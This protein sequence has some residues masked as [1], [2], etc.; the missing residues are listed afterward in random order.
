VDPEIV[1]FLTAVNSRPEVDLHA[2]AP[3]EALK[4][5]RS[6]SLTT[7]PLAAAGMKIRNFAIA[8]PGGNVPIRLYLPQSPGPHPVVINIHG[9][10]FVS[11]SLNMDDYRCTILARRLQSA[12][13][14]V[15]YRLAPEHRFPAA[16]EDCYAVL[17]W[18]ASGMGGDALD[19]ARIALL[20]SSSGGNLAACAALLARDRGGPA[21]LAQVLIYPVCD[22]DFE[23]PS[24]LGYRSGYFLSREHMRWYVAQYRNPSAELSSGYYMP[25]KAIDLKNLPPALV[26]TA[27]FDPLR[28]EAELF[29]GRLSE[30]GVRVVHLNCEGTIHGFLS[31]AP[32]SRNSTLTLGECAKFLETAFSSGPV[33]KKVG[34]RL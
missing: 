33:G 7:T 5:M 16:L 29:A 34:I 8:G 19:A 6:N 1:E 27:Q 13:V 9:G 15:D 11:G 31:A 24:Y 12:I 30:Q 14:S 20:G 17:K 2:L 18:A 25:L 22:D 21:I 28:D 32:G 4:V 10:G 26:V 23:R 3:A